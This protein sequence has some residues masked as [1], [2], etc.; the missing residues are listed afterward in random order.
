MF[1]N[2]CDIN[3]KE[4]R[5]NNIAG[6]VDMHMRF[7]SPTTIDS[8]WKLGP[9]L[10]LFAVAACSLALSLTIVSKN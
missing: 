4:G 5:I 7:A 10:M 1:K 2:A 9:L 8:D 6:D 3:I